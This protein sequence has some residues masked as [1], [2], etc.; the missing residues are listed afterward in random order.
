MSGSNLPQPYVGLATFYTVVIT[1]PASNT[2]PGDGFVDPTRVEYY[3]TDLANP[4]ASFTL[5]ASEAKRRANLRYSFMVAQL[6]LMA[7]IYIDN[8]VAAGADASTPPTTLTMIIEIERGDGVLVTRD[9]LNP[10]AVLMGTAALAR[11]VARALMENQTLE[12]DVFDPT[13]T[14]TTGPYGNTPAIRFGSRIMPL[15]IG[16]LSDN[17]ADAQTMVTVTTTPPPGTVQ[18]TAPGT[19]FNDFSPDY[20]GDFE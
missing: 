10:P 1:A 4:P 8:V 13:K 16:P 14:T 9:E 15:V 7:N 12:I 2:P 20:S 11:C 17:L 18:T 6:G 3:L 19:G 5:A